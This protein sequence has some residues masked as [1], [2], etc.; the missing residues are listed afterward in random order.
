MDR[1]VTM[2]L[3]TWQGMRARDPRRLTL[4]SAQWGMPYGIA[5]HAGPPDAAEL[6]RMLTRARDA[7]VRAIDTARAYGEAEAR[8]GGMLPAVP[9]AEGWRVITKL[10]ADVHEQG[11]GIAETLER[12]ATSLT[13]SRIALG[14]DALPVVLLHRFAHRHACGGKLWRT[15]LAERDA[16]RIGA[17]GVSAATPEEAWAAL[18]DPDVQ[19]LQVASSLLD[20]RLL[21]QEFFP[22][23]RELGRTVY[24]RSVFLQGVAHLDPATLPGFLEGLA[25]PLRTIRATAA[26]QGVSPRSL[27][28]GFAREFLPG[29]HPVIGCETEGQLH[30][31]LDDWTDESIDVAALA[32]LVDALPTLEPELVDPSRWPAPKAADSR[33]NQTPRGS[34]ASIAR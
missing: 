8:I 1:L 19:V 30:E 10:A 7:G 27:F 25:E 3:T 26:K 34:V 17:L 18:D 13:E 28:V 16:G 15:L 23:A 5:N 11:L 22:R 31:L 4:G 24:V 20:L 9:S 14:Q 29:A 21:R 2:D 33:V 32:P 12:V 6:E